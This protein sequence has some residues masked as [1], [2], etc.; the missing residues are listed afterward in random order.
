VYAPDGTAVRL[1][2]FPAASVAPLVA[3]VRAAVP[4]V[5]VA[6]EYETVFGHEPAYPAWSYGESA[7]DL[8][9]TAEELLARA[10]ERPVFKILAHHPTLPL[11]DF[12]VQARHSAGDEAETTHST[13]LALV[14]FSAPGVT[15][16]T[17]LT[18]WSAQLGI[19]PDDI[20]AFGD[21]PND[22]PMLR[23][24]GRPYAMA[25]AD[26][27]VKK[28]AR[29]HTTSNDEDGV[30]QVLEQFV[31]LK[32]TTR[33]PLQGRGELRDQPP[34]TR[35]RTQHRTNP[36]RDPAEPPGSVQARSAS[37]GTAGATACSIHT[38]GWSMRG[39]RITVSMP[40]FA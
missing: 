15:K 2:P 9:G 25:N 7:V 22:P 28:A 11:H 16:A 36:S 14:E 39:P 6:F 23:A 40:S 4:G 13:G 5:S 33:A 19:R 24:V 32:R 27:E 30:A 38:A 12:H 31:E 35:T 29:Y 20:A 18:R 8:I 17:A 34:R 3:R 37:R 10:P 26:P 21:M 1:S